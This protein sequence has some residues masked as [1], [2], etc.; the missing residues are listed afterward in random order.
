MA[1]EL[2]L[3]NLRKEFSGVVAVDQFST[4]FETGKIH[5]LIGKNGSGKSTLTN[6][7][8]G[9]VSPTSGD[10]FLDGKSVKFSSPL[11]AMKKGISTVHQEMSLVAELTVAE[12]IILGRWD[13]KGIKID[14]KTIEAKAVE[15]LQKVDPTINPKEKV[16]NL[17]VGQQQIVEIAKAMSTNPSILILDEPTSAL[18]AKEVKKLFDILK[19]LR[20][21]GVTQIYIS[22]RLHEL[23][24]IA[25]TIAVIRDGVFID[26]VP[27]SEVDHKKILHLM[28]GDIAAVE[29]EFREIEQKQIVLELKNLTSKNKF[30]D[31]SLKLHKGE[32]LG[33]A[34]M[35][36]SGRSE[37]LRAIFGVEKFDSGE[38]IVH[39]NSVS[40]PAPFKMKNL[41]LSYASEDRKSEGLVQIASVRNNL[42]TA[43]LDKISGCAG[44]IK[45]GQE[46]ILSE[47]QVKDL[48]IKI[49]TDLDPVSSLSGGNQQKVVIGNWLNTEPQIILCDEPSRG[50]DVEAKQQIFE[51]LWQQSQQGI[52]S[53]LVSTELEELLEI[54][55]TILIL[56]AGEI[57]GCYKASDLT[58]D[59]IYG[60]AM[61]DA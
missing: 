20:E 24:E 11:A 49:G 41:G 22:H 8:S 50:V 6:M 18:A 32:I 9:I 2:E 36:G 14:W 17:S 29:R 28:F 19:K 13:K 27:M 43:A 48:Q 60:K 10:I 25:D 54:C 45:E 35:L 12:N 56:K 30:N 15:V 23:K 40:K 4:I 34:G 38:I 21:Q 39:G 58:I 46:A 5:A 47:K 42:C 1:I 44:Y 53:I 61:G 59:Q 31:I 3:K 51:I 37:I 52:S 57:T 26:H 7:I 16:K 33:I 55:D